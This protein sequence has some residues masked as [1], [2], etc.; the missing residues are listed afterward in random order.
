MRGHTE[1]KKEDE[2]E[3]V[4]PGEVKCTFSIPDKE[5]PYE[6][7]AI[8]FK[9]SYAK[10][11]VD[12]IGIESNEVT[13]NIRL[14]YIRARNRMGYKEYCQMIMEQIEDV[15]AGKSVIEVQKKADNQIN[16]AE[17]EE[18]LDISERC[19]EPDKKFIK[20]NYVSRNIRIFK[21]LSLTLAFQCKRCGHL[22]EKKIEKGKKEPKDGSS[23]FPC[24]KCTILL[25]LEVYFNQLAPEGT[26]RANMAQIEYF[27][28]CK[29]TVKLVTFSAMCDKCGDIRKMPLHRKNT[30]SCGYVLEIAP[31]A[32][33]SSFEEIIPKQLSA[34]KKHATLGSM[35]ELFQAKGTCKHYKKSTRIFIFPCCNGR[36][37]CDICHNEKEQHIAVLAK[38]MICGICHSESQ[39]SPKCSN[40]ECKAALTGERS[41]F[42][43]GGKGTRNKITMSRKDSRKYKR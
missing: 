32:T 2:W 20:C 11:L 16:D 4:V 21:P 35:D 5:F 18:I 12:I 36:Y 1:N 7:D 31:P 39:I 25:K 28:I 33:G 27:G 10:D 30:C 19:I 43:E 3:E 38:R 15:L 24:S 22:H 23:T 29:I 42:W 8:S 9:Y 40:P 14:G 17:K 37:P 13:K 26:N 41:A 34:G 6:I